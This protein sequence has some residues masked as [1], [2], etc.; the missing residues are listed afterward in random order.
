[1]AITK[2]E[3]LVNPQVMAD[4]ISA[5]VENAIVVTPFATIDTTL[6]ATAGDTITVPRY[7]YIGDA[8]DVSEG[9]EVT[10][11]L[12]KATDVSY[13]VKKA[14]QAVNLTDEAALSGAGDPI[15]QINTQLADSM[16]AKV[17]SDAITALNGASKRF[18]SDSKAINYAGIVDAIDL[19]AEEL[20]TEKVMF[21]NPAQVTTLRKDSD[22]ISAD[23]YNQEV[24]MKG[25]IGMI[26]NTR[27]VAS[28][29][30]QKFAEWYKFDDAGTVTVS[31]SNIADIQKSLPS[32]KNGDKVTKVT[33]AAYLCP[34]V[35]LE[36]D[37][38]TEDEVAALTIFLKRD[39]N[40]ETER[41]TLKRTTAISVD[42]LYCAA[43]TNDAKVVVAAFKA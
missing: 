22:F 19:F 6:T 34:I 7:T 36:G 41:D 23:K 12:L 38:R 20:N 27:I 16:A 26:A 35:K 37:E 9:A 31:A 17:D 4:M 8:V 10:P 14:M 13:K 32:A 1:M 21:V 43:L 24:V 5:K 29:R 18:V 33:T 3:N 30:I 42:K 2:I 39:T 11:V 28:R 25:E 15:G 40:V